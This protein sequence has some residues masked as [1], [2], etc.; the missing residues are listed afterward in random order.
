MP[1]SAFELL[2]AAIMVVGLLGVVV[3]VLPGTLLVLGGVLLWATESQTAVGWVVLGVSTLAVAA[4]WIGKYL[5]A[6]RH[7]KRADVPNR[8]LVIG[9]LAGVVGFFVIPVI[10]LPL[11]FVLAVFLAELLRL[12]DR[13]RAWAATKA[14]IAA[15]GLTILVELAGAMVAI[16]AWAI[17][18]VLT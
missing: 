5:L 16:G 7:L 14:A 3:Q 18:I 13:S 2:C 1:V 6:G 11:L 8:S 9:G 15:T 10:G 17:A 4:A 12:R